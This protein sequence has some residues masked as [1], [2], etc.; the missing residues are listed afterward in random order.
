MFT[1]T[2]L[3][4]VSPEAQL[5]SCSHG[6]GFRGNITKFTSPGSKEKIQI[7]IPARFHQIQ[8]HM[9]KVYCIELFDKSW[10]I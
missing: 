4:N 3:L 5:Q 7:Q 9:L 8:A 10:Q 6:W 2:E 1:V